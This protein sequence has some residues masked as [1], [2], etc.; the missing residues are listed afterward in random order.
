MK[1]CAK[2]GQT[3]DDSWSICLQCDATLSNDPTAKV[4]HPAPQVKTAYKRSGGVTALAVLIIIGSAMSLMSAIAS[5]ETRSINPAFSNYLH[6]VIA[7]ASI[8]AAVFLLKLKNWARI[9][10]IAISI[11]VLADT[12]VTA[13]YVLAKA[14]KSYSDIVKKSM[15]EGLEEA[16]KNRKEGAPELTPEQRKF[17]GEKTAAAA[18]GMLGMILK[19][20][21]FLSALFNCLVIYF[22]ALPVIRKQFQK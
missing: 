7:P 9:A 2:C 12:V 22:F 5:S 4:S 11:I 10:V 15:N 17:I 13:P 3:Y 19:I 6:L 8:V 1:K 21:L 20:S 14:R 16:I 18:E